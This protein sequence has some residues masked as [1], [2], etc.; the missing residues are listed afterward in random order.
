MKNRLTRNIGLKIISLLASILIW[1]IVTTVSDP[2]VT[3][4]FYNIPVKLLNTDTITDSA[5]VY[6]VLD[7]SDVISKV[8]IKAA[9]SVI[10]NIDEEDIIAT[11]DVNDLSSLDTVSIKLSTTKNPEQLIN[12]TG[13][14]DTVKLDIQNKK[15]KTLALDMDIIGNPEE[16]YVITDKDTSQ[17]LVKIS[18]AESVVDSIAYAAVEIDVTGFKKDIGTNAEIKL[19]DSDKKPINT[20]K[21]TLNMRSAGVTVKIAKA[22][23]VPIFFTAEGEAAPGYCAVGEVDSDRDTIYVYGKEETI[24]N[25]TEIRIPQDAIN[26]ADLRSNFVTQVD[27]KQY[28]P[29]GIY[30]VDAADSKYT[31]TVHIE[32]EATKHIGLTDA[33]IKIAEIPAGYKATIGIDEGTIIDLVGLNDVLSK[34]NKDNIDATINVAKY[35]ESQE[36][37]EPQEGFYSVEVSFTLP[38]GVRVADSLMATLH[39][40]KND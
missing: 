8:T 3:Q 29:S 24:E 27:V 39:L 9:R 34:L 33:D 31:V 36:A 5:R 12:I 25:L 38:N 28:L 17:N 13:S 11:A 20:N 16:S 6:E 23:E 15:T 19:Y 18:G 35:F 2:A 4:S 7:N 10:V 22:K 14:S 26:I 37:S 32:A 40:V 1:A 30:L 21:V